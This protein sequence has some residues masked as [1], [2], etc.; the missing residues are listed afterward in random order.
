MEENKKEQTE[1]KSECSVEEILLYVLNG[2]QE[3]GMIV[4]KKYFTFLE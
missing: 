2:L 1:C 4:P 3:K